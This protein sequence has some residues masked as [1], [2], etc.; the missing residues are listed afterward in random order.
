MAG[1]GVGA[2]TRAYL[3]RNDYRF[4]PTYPHGWVT[5]L[6]LGLVAAFLGA[7]AVPAL[8]AREFTAVTFL[9]LAAQQFRE[10]RS[11]ER[12]SLAALEANERVPRGADYVEGIARVF[13]ARNYLAMLTA[14][15]TSAV[16]HWVG[17]A[18]GLLAGGAAL[19]LTGGL[20][21]GRQVGDIAVVRPAGLRFERTLLHVGDVMIMAVGLRE[22]RDY[23]LQHG[24]GVVL[25]PRDP[26]ARATLATLGQR[27]AIAHDAAA[28]VGLRK[29]FGTPEY[30]P[31]VRVDLDTGKAGLVI[32]PINPD[33]E[34][35]VE[36]VRQV[37]LLESARRR[38]L[39]GGR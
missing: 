1:V 12:E 13:E 24:R 27:Q 37:P 9:A 14:L 11:A 33:P 7:V 23:L 29:D 30:T 16:T 26:S 5:H 8:A 3:L 4:Y 18:P 36:A 31:L 15:V 10:V 2:L 39:G 32:V 22:A 34:A 38:L 20:R 35:V 6:S 21:R 28:A 25:E 19:L 17:L